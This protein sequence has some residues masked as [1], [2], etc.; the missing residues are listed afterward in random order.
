MRY[1]E[2]ND[3]TASQVIRKAVKVYIAFINRKAKE[4]E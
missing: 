2:K 1:G 4:Q 3:M